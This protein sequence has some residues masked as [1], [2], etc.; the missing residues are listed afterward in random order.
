MNNDD[1]QNDPLQPR[2]DI[3]N[4]LRDEEILEQDGANP[5]APADTEA[6]ARMPVDYPTTDTDID[7]G[8]A[9]F[10]GVADEAGYNPEPESDE[11]P[12]PLSPEDNK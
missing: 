11:Y 10:A 4:P 7:P 2:D 5:A 6:D 9:Y 3:F 1:V 8:G 12:D